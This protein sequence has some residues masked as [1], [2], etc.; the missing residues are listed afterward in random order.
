M[1]INKAMMKFYKEIGDMP[2][3]TPGQIAQCQEIGR[4]IIKEAILEH[5]NSCP[6]AVR[7]KMIAAVFLGAVLGSGLI[8]GIGPVL[9]KLIL[10]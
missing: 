9:A 2:D 4:V 3:L 1:D 7:W 6:H 5:Q 8:N 10:P